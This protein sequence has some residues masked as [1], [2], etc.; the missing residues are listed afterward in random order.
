MAIEGIILPEIKTIKEDKN[1]GTF[2]IEPL[3]PGY[4]MTIGNCLRRVLLSSLPGAAVTSVKIEGA[5]HE[6]SSISGVKEDVVNI[7]LNLKMLRVKIHKGEKHTLSLNVK[8]SKK[9]TAADIKTN[10]DVDV[11]N[12]DLYLFTINSDSGKVEMEINVE[13]GRGY[14]VYEDKKEKKKIGEIAMDALFTPTKKVSY[15]VEN[16]RVGQ[17]TNFDKITMNIT[18]DGT[19]SPKEAIVESA[20]ILIEQF[21]LLAGERKPTKVAKKE[22]GSL[23]K[24]EEKPEDLSVEEVDFSTRT[25]NALLKN[26]IKNMG[27]LS[28]L[29]KDEIGSLRGMGSK[30]QEEIE[31]KL[32]ELGLAIKTIKKE[33]KDKSKK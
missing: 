5:S 16:T 6:F 19:L 15:F 22:G 28:K 25:I 23:S 7:L 26:N 31:E 3:Y 4:G 21:S 2:I 14:V 24:K 29:T 9:V 32:A 8:G 1:S 30:A 18:T 20:K 12:K 27:D 33:K 17:A 10:A 11:I 13:E